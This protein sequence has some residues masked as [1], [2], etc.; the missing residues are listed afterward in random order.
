LITGLGY[1]SSFPL[2]CDGMALAR[3][4]LLFAGGSKALL[5]EGHGA[6]PDLAES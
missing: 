5:P 4:R 2:P 1:S 6:L 3:L